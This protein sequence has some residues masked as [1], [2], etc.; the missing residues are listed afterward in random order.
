MLG[1]EIAQPHAAAHA[2]AC[3]ADFI[4]PGEREQEEPCMLEGNARGRVQFQVCLVCLAEQSPRLQRSD[5]I[6]R[7][8][9]AIRAA[10]EPVDD[11]QACQLRGLKVELGVAEEEGGLARRLAAMPED[12]LRIVVE[13]VA[14][15]QL[16]NSIVAQAGPLT[17]GESARLVANQAQR[18]I[19]A[20][21]V[22]RITVIGHS[23]GRLL[24]GC[25]SRD[26]GSKRI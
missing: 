24:L 19:Q 8:E 26:F 23:H 20:L 25:N 9:A 11:V 17:N 2:A 16:A 13:H 10:Q 21:A 4:V 12:A 15:V 22:P 7:F 14:A 1:Q 5:A 3:D 6:V 18:K